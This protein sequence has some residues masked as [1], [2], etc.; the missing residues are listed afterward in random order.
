IP[1]TKGLPLPDVPKVTGGVFAEYTFRGL[2]RWSAT[3]RS[4]YS[5]TDRSL[6]Q[7]AVGASFAP[8]LGALSLL[9]ARLTLQ[10]ENFEAAIYGSNLLNDVEK[11]YLERDA[12]F[13]VP[14]RLRYSV[15][16]PRRVGISLSY[17]F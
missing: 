13:S 10:C 4:D 1:G 9:S 11:T 3:L 16:T 14:D 5:Y 2:G 8:D 12:S 7:Y 6:S 15:N 17:K